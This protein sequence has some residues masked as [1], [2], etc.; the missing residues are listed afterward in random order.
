MPKL[1]RQFTLPMPMWVNHIMASLFLNQDALFLHHQ[2]R[3]L[4][5]T[6]DY[7]SLKNEQGFSVDN[8]NKAVLPVDSDVG[9]INFRNWLRILA[10]GRIP[11]KY[12]PAMP[13]ANN[14]IVFDVWNGHTKYCHVCQTALKN[15]KRARLAAFLVATCLAIIRPASSKIVN[16][17]GVLATAGTGLVL[18]KLVG[19]FYRYEFSHAHND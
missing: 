14:D 3:H 9:V 13:E 10:G 4:R 19:L 5:A 7:S 1:L 15:I 12:S 17:S 11:Y 8:Y 16:L 6:G 2:E 18:N